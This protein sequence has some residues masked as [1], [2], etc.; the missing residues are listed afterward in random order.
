[1]NKKIILA[2]I[3]TILAFGIGISIVQSAQN[4]EKYSK[5]FY[6]DATFYQDK[7]YVQINFDDSSGKT[8]NVVLEVLGMQTSYQKTFTCPHLETQVPF[9]GV[10]EYG[11]KTMPI[12]LVVDHPEFGKVGL[13]T[14]VH[15]QGEQPNKIIFSNL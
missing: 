13:K 5:V 3:C 8:T 2:V 12:T 4:A 6:L 7:H 14:E 15:N 1:M 10:P 9:D 11:W